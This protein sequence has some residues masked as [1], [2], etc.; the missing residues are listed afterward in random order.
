MIARRCGAAIT[1][2]RLPPCPRGRSVNG[3][4]V[5]LRNAARGFLAPLA[6]ILSPGQRSRFI[7]SLKL[8]AGRGVGM[9]VVFIS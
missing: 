7:L 4:S 8:L 9:L 5:R 6:R 1:P 3:P 2:S